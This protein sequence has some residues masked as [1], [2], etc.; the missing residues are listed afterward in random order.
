MHQFAVF[1]LIHRALHQFIKSVA[2]HFRLL[3]AREHAGY[4]RQRRDGARS[5]DRRPDQRAGGHVT[6]H[7]HKAAHQQHHDVNDGLH[8]RVQVSSSPVRKRCFM[9]MDEATSLVW[10][11]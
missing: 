7:Y 5:Q 11:H 4:L 10:F 2:R 9:L 8:F 3:P 6:V 1:R